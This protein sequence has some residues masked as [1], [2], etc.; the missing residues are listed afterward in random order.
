MTVRSFT[1]AL[2]RFRTVLGVAGVAASL[3]VAGSRYTAQQADAQAIVAGAQAP[4]KKGHVD[5]IAEGQTI[6]AN[7][8]ATV[9]LHFRIDPNFH[10]NSHTPKSEMLIPTKIAVEDLTGAEVSDV[11]FPVGTPYSFAFEPKTKLDVYTGDFTLTA[12]I[13]AK[14]GT[15]T[16]KAA[17]HYQACDQA[18]C[19]P[20]K[21]LPVEQPFTAK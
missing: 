6:A 1:T 10:I 19:Y 15:Y 4:A 21:T 13:K 14:P 9:K 16:L 12:H 11:D 3:L 7:K 8:P 2:N 20:P 17:L 18:A 5:F